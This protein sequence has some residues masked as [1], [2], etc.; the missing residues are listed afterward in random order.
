M[1][2]VLLGLLLLVLKLAEFG[3]VGLWSWWAVLSPFAC[4]AV[5]WTVADASGYNKRRAMARMQ[6]RKDQRRERNMEALGTTE[7]K[8]KR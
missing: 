3:P 4:A 6:A 1:Y 5:W 2:F 7:E 8:R